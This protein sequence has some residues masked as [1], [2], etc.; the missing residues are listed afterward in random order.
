MCT[1]RSQI[2]CQVYGGLLGGELLSLH[3]K[4]EIDCSGLLLG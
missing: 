2:S 4:E 1:L 3:G